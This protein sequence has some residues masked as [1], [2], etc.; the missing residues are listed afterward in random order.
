VHCSRL[1]WSGTDRK[2]SLGSGPVPDHVGTSCLADTRLVGCSDLHK[3][4]CYMENWLMRI[5]FACHVS[6]VLFEM[7]KE[8]HSVN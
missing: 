6:E 1:V 3:G 4:C 5:S 7:Y 2:G 8:M